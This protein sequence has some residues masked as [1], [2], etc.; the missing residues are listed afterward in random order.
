MLISI[1]GIDACGK[2]TISK[3]LEK[4]L[5]NQAENVVRFSCPNSESVSGMLIQA[6][7]MGWL[8]IGTRTNDGGQAEAEIRQC[9]HIVNRLDSL[10][11]GLWG[12]SKT[13][14]IADRYIDSTMA[15]GIASGV[16]RAWLQRVKR[17]LPQPDLS[18]LL[19]I[20]V[21]ESFRRRPER[22][23]SIESDARLLASVRAAYLD[24]FSG[25]S[26]HRVV[27]DATGSVDQTFLAVIEAISNIKQVMSTIF[28]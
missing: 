22:R 8:D 17:C 3:L 2:N 15:Y 5:V 10:P 16:D 18:I 9:L 19:D 11:E 23:D 1:E 20:P 27:V 28:M 24:L 4:Y 25:R 13:I 7:D 21:E 14:F 12:R 26:M 6:I